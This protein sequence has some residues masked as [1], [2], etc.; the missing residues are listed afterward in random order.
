MAE[1][2]VQTGKRAEPAIL[3]QII[4]V[5]EMQNDIEAMKK[6]YSTDEAW[7]RHRRFYEEGPSREWRELY[8]DVAAVLGEDPASE[9]AQELADRW[10]ELGVRAIQ[11]A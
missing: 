2:A 7:E 1:D 5:I 6:Y 8:R 9:V 3:K 10:L 11:S 4:E